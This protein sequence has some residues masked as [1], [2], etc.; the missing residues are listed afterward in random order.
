MKPQAGEK[1]AWPFILPTGVRAGT[2]SCR[3]TQ[4][5]I[6]RT[7]GRTIAL[8]EMHPGSGQQTETALLLM[9]VKQVAAEKLRTAGNCLLLLEGALLFGRRRPTVQPPFVEAGKEGRMGRNRKAS[10]G[11]Q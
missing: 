8:P 11:G 2:Q 3:G 1:P 10:L 5:I 4:S 9:A 6:C 7:D